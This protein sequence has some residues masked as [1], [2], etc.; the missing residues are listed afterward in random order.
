[1]SKQEHQISKE[2]RKKR[3][4]FDLSQQDSFPCYQTSDV[5]VEFGAIGLVYSDGDEGTKAGTAID[6]RERATGKKTQE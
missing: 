4:L 1:M 6:R 3:T 5:L 2:K